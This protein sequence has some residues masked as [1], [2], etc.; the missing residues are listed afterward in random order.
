MTYETEDRI[1]NG[2]RPEDGAPSAAS[3]TSSGRRLLPMHYGMD[4]ILGMLQSIQRP[5]LLLAMSSLRTS[6]AS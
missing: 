3:L 1:D 6:R 2:Q 4:I 5:T